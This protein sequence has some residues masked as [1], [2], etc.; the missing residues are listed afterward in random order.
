[1][2]MVSR[3]ASH[4]SGREIGFPQTRVPIF[5]ALGPRKMCFTTGSSSAN[6]R[7]QLIHHLAGTC[8]ETKYEMLTFGKFHKLALVALIATLPIVGSAADRCAPLFASTQSDFVA[9]EPAGPAPSDPA[10]RARAV[11]GHTPPRSTFEWLARLRASGRLTY[12]GRHYSLN[13]TEFLASNEGDWHRTPFDWKP[14]EVL[15]AFGTNSAWEIAANKQAKTL[16]LADWSPL[17]LF[18]H[19]YLIEPLL[20]ISTTPQQLMLH[21]AGL[22]PAGV[23]SLDSSSLAAILAGRFEMRPE[24]IG[25]FLTY[26]SEKKEINDEELEFFSQYYRSRDMRAKFMRMFGEDSSPFRELRDPGFANFNLFFELRY[27]ETPPGMLAMSVMHNQKHFDYIR[28]LYLNRHVE[29]VLSAVND[30]AMYQSVQNQHPNA[31]SWTLSLTNI[32]DMDYNGLTFQELKN[33][34]SGVIGVAGISPSKSLT[35]FRTTNFRP[36]HGFYRYD[37][38]TASDVPQVDERDSRANQRG[39]RASGW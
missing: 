17:P 30:L 36:P 7:K 10:R 6:N 12:E 24:A 3:P 29:Y 5:G 20:R 37:I 31:Q 13:G 18:A 23:R 22:D 16:V 28:G 38:K 27:N 19:A 15:V 14:T 2:F 25:R 9:K 21:L 1:M 39:R 4:S 11:Q 35:V 26:L 33:L 34:L 32:F 8:I